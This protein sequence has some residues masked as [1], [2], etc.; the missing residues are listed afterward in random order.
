MVVDNAGTLEEYHQTY[1]VVCNSEILEFIM[2]NPGKAKRV[3]IVV[4]WDDGTETKYKISTRIQGLLSKALKN[5]TSTIR[6]RYRALMRG[7]NTILR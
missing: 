4:E 3:R 5:N 1:D 7:R 2:N 6:N